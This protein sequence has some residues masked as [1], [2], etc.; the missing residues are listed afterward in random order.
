MLTCLQNFFIYA[1][2]NPTSTGNV[3]SFVGHEDGV[4]TTFKLRLK[5]DEDASK[6]KAALDREIALVGV[7]T[8]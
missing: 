7:K 6:L 1:G 2:L 4:P 3:V 5:T 8:P